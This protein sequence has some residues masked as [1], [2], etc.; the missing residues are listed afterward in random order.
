M[1]L[2][3]NN[4]TYI[5]A[6]AVAHKGTYCAN[7][8]INKHNKNKIDVTNAERPVLPPAATPAIISTLIVVLFSSSLKILFSIF[9]FNSPSCN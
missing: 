4:P 3:I 9:L 6:G 7:G 1:F 5:K 2:H 8:A